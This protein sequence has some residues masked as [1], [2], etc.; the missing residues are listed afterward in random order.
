MF[1]LLLL[2]LSLSGDGCLSVLARFGVDPTNLKSLLKSFTFVTAKPQDADKLDPH[3]NG[4][5][6]NVLDSLGA[7]FEFMFS[8]NLKY[9]RDYRIVLKRERG[10][11]NSSSSSGGTGTVGNRGDTHLLCFWCLNPSVAFSRLA[12]VARSVILTSGTLAP[13]DSFAS[14][15]GVTFETRLEA[16][17]VIEKSQVMTHVVT[18]GP[19][20][21]SLNA[22][23]K[24]SD[25]I[26]F[27]DEIGRV[28][29]E[30]CSRTPGGI[31][32]FLPSYSLLEKLVTRW[33][34]SHTK[35]WS[36]LARMK[37]LVVEPKGSGTKFDLAMEKFTQANEKYQK[38]WNSNHN[39]KGGGGGG[40]GGDG[41]GNRTTKRVTEIAYEE[42]PCDDDFDISATP[43]PSSSSTS[44][45]PFSSTPSSFR[46]K[47]D[48]A[49]SQT[50]GIFFGVN[51]G[52]LS[53]GIDFADYQARAVILIGIP[54][55][56]AK[57]SKV[58]LKRSHNDQQKRLVKDDLLTGSQWY[59]LQAYRAVNQSI[60]RAIR[61]RYDYGA[62][63]LV[64]ERY[65]DTKVQ[66]SLSKWIQ[67]TI[68]QG[69]GR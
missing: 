54:F 33:R 40:G 48:S 51:R 5:A 39:N 20:G 22:S 31:L 64:D 50:G 8:Q 67:P 29:E 9:L 4:I 32:V 37:R 3:V 34:S 60:G 61:H 19:T 24:H 58:T 56:N 59:A 47:L 1:Y 23:F 12:S 10:N 2:L 35:Q 55:P 42:E 62:I 53:E 63:F 45:T 28:V 11:I 18:R 27:Q 14:E 30:I 15:L 69:S 17:H 6:T 36:V 44:S 26:M 16:P 49:T 41:G 66:Q 68:Q 25:D 46:S 52:K 21:V 43:A 13:M 7:M 65:R 38:E 57:D